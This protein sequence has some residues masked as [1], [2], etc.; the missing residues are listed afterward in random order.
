MSHRCAVVAQWPG[1]AFTCIVQVCS[2]LLNEVLWLPKRRKR[3]VALTKDPYAGCFLVATPIIGAEPFFRTVIF[4]LAHDP[5]GTVGV[6]LN[7]PTELAAEDHI[8]GVDGKLSAPGLVFIGGPVQPE[9]AI[10]VT[11]K[12]NTEPMNAIGESGIGTVELTLDLDLEG[13]LRIFAGYAGWDAQQLAAEM[14]EGAW[15]VVRC[16]SDEVF[17]DEIDDMW[18]RSVQRAPGYIPLYRTYPADPTEN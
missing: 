7:R 13:D 17:T 15:W 1:D 18:G 8:E 6:I 10:A 4:L 16:D 14:D 3:A 2:T 5:V 12:E 9:T 11:R